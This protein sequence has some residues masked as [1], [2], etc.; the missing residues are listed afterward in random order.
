[1]RRMTRH[2]ATSQRLEASW[3]RSGRTV[4]TAPALDRTNLA[5]TAHQPVRLTRTTTSLTTVL[6]WLSAQPLTSPE[7]LW[8]R[9]ISGAE[10]RILDQRL[11][12]AALNATLRALFSVAH[13][14]IPHRLGP[15]RRD[16]RGVKGSV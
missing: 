2:Q 11:T 8:N 3:S 10:V 6:I 14:I 1:M 15:H 7:S 16:G 13:I 4:T 12:D 9:A 5:I